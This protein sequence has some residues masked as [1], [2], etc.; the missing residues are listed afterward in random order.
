M[1]KVLNHRRTKNLQREQVLAAVSLTPE[2]A[3]IPESLSSRAWLTSGKFFLA[4]DF[5]LGAFLGPWGNLPRGALKLASL[6]SSHELD[7]YASVC[8][9]LDGE[10]M[11]S[12][13]VSLAKRFLPGRPLF[14][15]IATRLSCKFSSSSDS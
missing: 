1:K 10:S 11:V 4:L 8:S 12:S 5:L 6:D 7:S 3:L 14:L 15:S 9:P 2:I 13:D